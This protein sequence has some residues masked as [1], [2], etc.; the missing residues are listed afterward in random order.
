M[1]SLFYASA[2]TGLGFI[3]VSL[4]WNAWKR[5]G[6]TQLTWGGWFLII[7]AVIAWGYASGKGRG[8]AIGSILISLQALAFIIFNAW[9]ER[10]TKRKSKP[11]KK[12]PQVLSEKVDWTVYA[13]R[14]GMA[15][16][17]GPIAGIISFSAALGLH[18]VLGMMQVEAANAFAISV[19]VFPIV[20]ASLSI[21]LL[22]STRSVFKTVVLSCMAL[23]SALALVLGN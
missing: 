3:G 22:I 13:S 16:L 10:G 11:L 17:V 5:R 23:L 19:Y 8:L 4:L 21:F 18:E 15:C 14:I 7:A 2:G 9:S 1:T 20:W 6:A 12:V